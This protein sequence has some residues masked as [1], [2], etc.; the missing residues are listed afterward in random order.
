MCSCC[1]CK[2]PEPISSSQPLLGRS[3]SRCIWKCS[4]GA[5]KLPRH[6]HTSRYSVVYW[7]LT[8]GPCLFSSSPERD[9]QGP[10]ARRQLLRNAAAVIGATRALQQALGELIGAASRF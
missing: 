2:L 9:A 4:G 6:K 1:T 10:R 8:V 5:H 3:C 7:L